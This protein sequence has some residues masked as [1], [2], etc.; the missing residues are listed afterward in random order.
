MIHT[1][2]SC[3][4]SHYQRWQAELL[5]FTHRMFRQ[6]GGIT[7]LLASGKD[8]C[9]HDMPA[10][11]HPSYRK[12]PFTGDD[13]APYNKPAGIAH[14]L[15]RADFPEE[16]VLILDPDCVFTNQ[17]TRTARRGRPAAHKVGI[18]NPPYKKDI[19]DLFKFKPEA[20][21]EVAVPILI[22]RDDLEMVAPRWLAVTETLRASDIVKPDNHRWMIEM[23]GYVVG[24]AQVGLKHDSLRLQ[25]YPHESDPDGAPIMHYA[26]KVEHTTTTTEKR[27]PWRRKPK[28]SEHKWVWW[29]QTYKP[30]SIVP[31]PPPDCP[32]CMH[33]LVKI[34]NACARS[35]C[36]EPYP[37]TA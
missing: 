13:Y 1:V 36:G 20:L 30:W 33:R 35:K 34:L 26:W 24:A 22:H 29:K 23:W 21:E 17:V 12:H 11:V 27:R 31:E 7:K 18:L 5:I 8:F 6:P 2:F 32:A 9:L 16:T 37:V 25:T 15:P 14:W 28:T 4:P 19:A 3:E 10:H